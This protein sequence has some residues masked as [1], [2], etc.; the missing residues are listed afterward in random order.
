MPQTVCHSGGATVLGYVSNH[1]VCIWHFGFMP[2]HEKYL[3]FRQSNDWVVLLYT[4]TT[5]YINCFDINK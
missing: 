3:K 5:S 2:K 1:V 4:R